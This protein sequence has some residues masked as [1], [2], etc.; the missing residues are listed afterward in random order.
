MTKF[1]PKEFKSFTD[2]PEEERGNFQELEGDGFVKKEVET[3]PEV[4][5]RMGMVEDQIINTLK[6]E[7]EASGVSREESF[8]RYSEAGNKNDYKN[9]RLYGEMLKKYS[10]I[11]FLL[12]GKDYD[13]DIKQAF[14]KRYDS[15]GY[16]EKTQTSFI[17]SVNPQ[18][19]EVISRLLTDKR[20]TKNVD[21]VRLLEDE[22]SIEAVFDYIKAKD[23]YVVAMLIDKSQ[24]K[25]FK[26][27]AFR[28]ISE[29]INSLDPAIKRGVEYHLDSIQAKLAE[30]LILS[31]NQADFFNLV[32]NGLMKVESANSFLHKIESD[33]VLNWLATKS[34][35]VK[36]VI[37]I[38][39]FVA[40]P[41]IFGKVIETQGV[42]FKNLD[43]QRKSE[44]IKLAEQYLNALNS[45]PQIF[46]A[47]K[48]G[49]NNKFVIG[50]TTNDESKYYISW[51][52]TESH[53]Y[54]KDIFESLQ[55]KFRININ[56]DFRSGGY[57]QLG[58]KDGKT[59]AFFN[60]SSGDFGN[61]SHKVLERF[62]EKLKEALGNSLGTEV[63]VR[64]DISR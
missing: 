10:D 46:E 34:S 9:Q 19:L 59:I 40:D 28:E 30:Y 45:G 63:E 14:K 16:S 32:E 25:D 15:L 38:F 27:R 33:E 57:I 62:K 47:D 11:E 6:H 39:K 58:Q 29:I 49:D 41:A 52:N 23:F 1:N 64:I 36:A 17:E 54:H 61:Y 56:N 53:G 48:L 7:L 50:I 18:D 22:S 31:G 12:S 2:L 55:S 44:V 35:N 5:H 8:L 13:E 21:L 24:D 3:N 26:I 37:I 60:S 51:S 4:A 42:E 20:F 43:E